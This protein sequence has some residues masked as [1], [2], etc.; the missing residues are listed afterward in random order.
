MAGLRPAAVLVPVVER[1]DG[2]R[3]ILT[4]RTDELRHHPGQISLPGGRAEA[5][6][7]DAVATAL[8]ETREEIGV[9]ATQ[10]DVIGFLDDYPTTTGFRVTPVVGCLPED[11]C[12]QPDGREVAEIFEVP[13]A[14]LLDAG[15]YDRR[16]FDRDGLR[17]PNYALTHEHR[18]IW[19]V[20]AGILHHM[21]QRLSASA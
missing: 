17:L 13:L 1:A 18:F 10:V 19:G 12:Y 20:T 21:A 8:R 2:P 11:C 4:Q 6:D 15:N 5:A 9:C 16:W 3:V 14:R 7:A